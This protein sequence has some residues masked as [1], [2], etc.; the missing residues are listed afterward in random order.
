MAAIQESSVMWYG[1]RGPQPSKDNSD[2][3]KTMQADHAFVFSITGQCVRCQKRE[4]AHP[5]LRADGPDP[6]TECPVD[7]RSIQTTMLI[8]DGGWEWR[9]CPFCHHQVEPYFPSIG[10]QGP[11]GGKGRGELTTS[12][13]K[14]LTGFF[15]WW[16]YNGGDDARP[17][18]D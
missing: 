12:M 2:E 10:A 5:K 3:Q 18:D 9:R 4:D 11:L 1:P 7:H 16:R 6:M 17:S 14:R 8:G 15:G 13:K